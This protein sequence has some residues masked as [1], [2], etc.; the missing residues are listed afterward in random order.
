M[1]DILLKRYLWLIDILR[2]RGELTYEEISS[3]WERSAVNDNGST[4]SKRTLYNH[5]QAVGRQFGIEIS[6]RRGRNLNYY[7]IANPEALSDNGMNSWLIENFSVSTLLLENKDLADKILLDEVPSGRLYLDDLLAAIRD[8]NVVRLSYCNFSG[9]GY[10]GLEA[11]PLCVKLFKRRWYVLTRLTDNGKLRIFALDRITSLEKTKRKY[12]YPSDFSP[13]E[14]FAPYFGIIALT[15]DKPEIIRLRI[16][17]ELRGYLKTLPIHHSQR[18]VEEADNHMDI[19]VKVA[20]TFDF[21]QELL[22]HREQLEVMTP[23]SL[24]K[25]IYSVISKMSDLY[26][27]PNESI[28]ENQKDDKIQFDLSAPGLTII[29]GRPAMGKTALMLSIALDMAMRGTPVAIFSLEMS[30]PQLIIRLL[31][32]VGD[33]PLNNISDLPL[34]NISDLP[35]NNIRLRRYKLSDSEIAQVTEASEKL[36]NLPLFIDDTASLSVTELRTK[37]ERLVREYGV[38]MIAIDYLELISDGENSIPQDSGIGSIAHSLKEL[39]KEFD[40]SVI[41]LMQLKRE[42]GDKIR[43][44]E[45]PVLSDISEVDS[46]EQDADTICL[47]HRPKLYT[48]NRRDN[49][50]QEKI[51]LIYVKSPNGTRKVEMLFCQ[52]NLRFETL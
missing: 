34:N 8:E 22:L 49:D 3:A 6:C 15:G 14:F 41:A 47:I 7:Y 1:V 26:R 32:N 4:L 50:I 42:T 5:C 51:E 52:E 11:E 46:I 37:A 36:Q 43:E 10:D 30:I 48:W 27:V 40:I 17:D 2:R 33:L 38:K 19:T 13:T 29:G 25:E 39:A 9:R 44:I 16:F 18:I 28:F 31:S 45:R 12:I 24:R 21:V 20:P 35:L 23:E